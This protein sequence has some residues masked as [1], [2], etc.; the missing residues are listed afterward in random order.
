M[1]AG[2]RDAAAQDVASELADGSSDATSETAA[3]D[4]NVDACAAC[5]TGSICV[6]DLT[7]GGAFI[8]PDDAGQCP[9]GLVIIP[10]S[11]GCSSPPSMHC[12]PLPAA[13][14]AAAGNLEPSH[15][16]CVP[17]ICPAALY[18]CTDLTPTLTECLQA[19]P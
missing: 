3:G 1:D 6:E 12:V 16:S 4:A 13:C 10:Q 7:V 8:P 15:C 17:S 5:A 19:A 2:V 9:N 14:T 11:R 18:M